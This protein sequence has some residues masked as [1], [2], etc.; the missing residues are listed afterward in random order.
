MKVILHYSKTKILVSM[1]FWLFVIVLQE[2]LT[3]KKILHFSFFLNVGVFEFC[4]TSLW[5]YKNSS[6]PN[7][8]LKSREKD[9][10]EKLELGVLRKGQKL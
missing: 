5:P 6:S 8:K 7:I 2:R 9:W 10:F 1:N 4:E 3:I